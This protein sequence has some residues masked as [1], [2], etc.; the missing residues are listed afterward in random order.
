[1]WKEELLY[2]LTSSQEKMVTLT[3]LGGTSGGV[4]TERVLSVSWWSSRG[5]ALG[6]FSWK[7]EPSWNSVN[8]Q[9]TK[10][11]QGMVFYNQA[12]FISV[13]NRAGKVP[14][15]HHPVYL[16]SSLLWQ[17][18]LTSTV[19]SAGSDICFVSSLKWR[20][21]VLLLSSCV[22]RLWNL[23]T[24][25]CLEMPKKFYTHP[26][27]LQYVVTLIHKSEMLMFAEYWNCVQ[28]VM[29]LLVNVNSVTLV[30]V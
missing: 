16:P 17:K 20:M 6:V 3:C 23:G 28:N 14:T 27:C 24:Q 13:K 19:S 26:G 30:N 9:N 1:M 22:E 11:L 8:G 18:C 2:K 7:M 29:D 25:F 15:F 4:D 12:Y 10:K 5:L 21:G